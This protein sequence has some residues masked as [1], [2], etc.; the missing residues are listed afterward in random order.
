MSIGWIDGSERRNYELLEGETSI[1]RRPDCD[2]V[3]MNSQVS[4]RHAQITGVSGTF[5]VADLGS[6]NGTYVNGVRVSEQV[7]KE[8]DRIE[9]GKDRIPLLFTADPTKFPGDDAIALERAL[10]GLKLSGSDEPTV[11]QKISW[12]LDFQQQWGKTLTSETAF[13]QILR[14][15]LNLSG[16]ERAFIL[17][18]EQQKFSYAAGMLTTGAKLEEHEFRTSRSVID[19]VA[20]TG[21]AVFMVERLDDSFAAQASIIATGAKAIA[22][23]P[24]RGIPADAGTP[25][26]LGILYLDS[27][28][29][30]HA[31]SGLD[32]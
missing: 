16:A 13:D 3:V 30:M 20:T 28:Q 29:P 21:T 12:I 22:C 7:L 10:G 6:A 11:L 14:S 2:I 23:L 25:T 15:A 17:I 8:A 1:G 9:L 24:L 18:R 32:E 4:R 19:H 27:T 31:L 5:T 26:I